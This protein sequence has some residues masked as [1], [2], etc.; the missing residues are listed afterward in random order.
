VVAVAT[1][2]QTLTA[3]RSGD[4]DMIP[5]SPTEIPQ[6]SGF[7]ISLRA[8]SNSTLQ[9]PVCKTRKPLDDVRVRQALN[10]ATDKDE[11][12]AALLAGKG[13]PMEALFTK[14]SAFFPKSLAG[15]YEY[16]VGKAKKLLK[17]AGVANG[18]EL[19]II[20]IAGNT[21]SQ[22]LAEV[23]QQ[24]WAK[25]GIQLHITP[26]TAIGQD[27]YISNREPLFTLPFTRAGVSKVTTQY[28]GDQ[29]GNVCR[30]NDPEL[31]SLVDQLG[32]VA[33]DSTQAVELWQKTQERIFDQALS[34]WAL[35]QPITWA[36]DGKQ[37]ANVSVV[38]G[39]I[40][41]PDF[42]SIYVKRT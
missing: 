25:V 14:D 3:L 18:T 28:V 22:R 42:F 2:P 29:I 17:A 21:T 27:F 31:N 9:I 13:E 38:S 6:L 5:I 41:Y 11:L 30:W 33:T 12:N 7:D 1:G 19:G 16:N 37:L 4:V 10:Y 20:T 24:Q 36:Y 8:D 23:L 40:Q 34:V 26:S 15:K 32:A 35:F 39:L